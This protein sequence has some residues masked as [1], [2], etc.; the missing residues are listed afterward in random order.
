MDS[1]AKIR[2]KVGLMEVEYEG[3][4]S[5]LKDGLEDLLSRMADI[6]T[7]VPAEPEQIVA[8]PNGGDPSAKSNGYDF[9]TS[10]IAAHLEAKTATELAICALAKL[11]LVDGKTGAKRAEIHEEMKS[12]TAYYNKNMSTNLSKSLAT[13]TKNKRINHGANGCYS[14]SADER[15]SIEAKIADIG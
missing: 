13:L 5:F 6:S 8:A 15:K 2:I 14:L 1:G 10:T 4:A 3:D 12:A 11:E 7:K 9:S